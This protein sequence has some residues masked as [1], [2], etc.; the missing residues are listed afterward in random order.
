MAVSKV[1]RD[2]FLAAIFLHMALRNTDSPQLQFG[3]PF[4]PARC[5]ILTRDPI[6]MIHELEVDALKLLAAHHS[7]HCDN[8]F[9]LLSSVLDFVHNNHWRLGEYR[10]R[11]AWVDKDRCNIWS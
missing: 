4:P 1:V 8:D 9:I 7:L 11:R 6:F 5:R 10:K 3:T 2:R